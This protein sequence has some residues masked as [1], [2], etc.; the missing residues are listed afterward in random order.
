MLATTAD[1]PTGLD[2]ATCTRPLSAMASSGKPLYLPAAVSDLLKRMLIGLRTPGKAFISSSA[3][4]IREYRE[5]FLPQVTVQNRA[6]PVGHSPT[7]DIWPN[8][9]LSTVPC[10]EPPDRSR[11][12]SD[13]VRADPCFMD[14]YVPNRARTGNS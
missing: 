9:Q 7:S 1:G 10:S 6:L 4:M 2:G 12:R 14:N 11:L 13:S 8:G 5:L 3:T